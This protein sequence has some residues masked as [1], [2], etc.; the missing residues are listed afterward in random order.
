MGSLTPPGDAGIGVE[1]AFERATVA[2]L[3][4]VD[5]APVPPLKLGGAI[6]GASGERRHLVRDCGALRDMIGAPA[7]DV[8]RAQRLRQRRGVAAGPGDRDRLLG[9]RLASARSRAVDLDRQPREQPRSQPFVVR[10][11]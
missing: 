2:K 5:D 1:L 4:Q 11:R 3:E 9:E 8:P 7:G 6:A 10:R